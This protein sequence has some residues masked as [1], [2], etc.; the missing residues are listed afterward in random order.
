MDEWSLSI[1]HTHDQLSCMQ[2]RESEEG[3][4]SGYQYVLPLPERVPEDGPRA[5][6]Q[7]EKKRK[8]ESR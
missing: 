2:C 3:C 7:K 5:I 1:V 6:R 4:V 8:K